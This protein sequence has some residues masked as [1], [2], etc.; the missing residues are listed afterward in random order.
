MS[1]SKATQILG[2]VK[3]KYGQTNDQHRQHVAHP[4]RIPA[5]RCSIPSSSIH[6]R[7]F[8]LSHIPT[9][10]H[11]DTNLAPQSPRPTSHSEAINPMFEGKATQSPASHR[12]AFGLRERFF[13]FHG[14]VVS[15]SFVR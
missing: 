14:D 1:V 9:C 5:Y 4:R 15:A 13:Y 8:A 12:G 7:R 3:K 2:M 6:T 10:K 11:G